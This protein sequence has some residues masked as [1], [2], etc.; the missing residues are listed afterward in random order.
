MRSRIILTIGLFAIT[1]FPCSAQRAQPP[2]L[3]APTTS[4]TT[5]MSPVYSPPTQSERFRTYLRH[6]YG[7]TSFLEAGAR[8]G[9]EQARNNPSQWPQGAEG[10]AER[11]GSAMG[12]IAVRGTTEYLIAD[13]FREDL[14]RVRCSHPC[15]ES[16][17]KL[18]FEDSFLA[19][20]GEDGHE[21]FSMA[22]LIGPFSGSAVAVNT[23]YPSGSGRSNILRGAGL[24]FG[25]IY[26]RNL[27]RVSIYK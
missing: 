5:R 27:L 23:W 3:D 24:Q 14:Q 17:F 16:R 22:R 12:E 13:L 4:T 8:G 6:T 20:R 9:I 21:A 19:K 10:Y 26:V 1:S 18:A 2:I 15:S 7:W 11:F 25:L